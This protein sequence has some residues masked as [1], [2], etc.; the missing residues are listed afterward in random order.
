MKT[1]LNDD[2]DVLCK[3]GVNKKWLILFLSCFG[4]VLKYITKLGDFYCFD[5]PGAVAP[6][7]LKRFP[8][9]PN[10]MKILYSVYSLPNTI[11]P[12]LGGLAIYKYG[13]RTMFL[14]FGFL[15]FS[16]QFFLVL[17]C[18]FSSAPIM[19]FGIILS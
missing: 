8:D 2:N 6:Q 17:G 18:S 14:I 9:N 12:I 13:Y 15:V 19:I 16:G 10:I 4:L 7:L 3:S 1:D 11:L 5:S